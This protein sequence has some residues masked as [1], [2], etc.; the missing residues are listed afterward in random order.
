MSAYPFLGER[1][2]H[3]YG[4]VAMAVVPYVLNRDKCTPQLSPEL[5]ARHRPWSCTFHCND[6]G[7]REFVAFGGKAGMLAAVQAELGPRIP[8]GEQA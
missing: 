3:L 6:G 7:P 4:H 5:R 2:D 1:A 8:K